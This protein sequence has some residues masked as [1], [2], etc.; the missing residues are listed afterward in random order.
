[1]SS[2]SAL[3]S[4]RYRSQ[5]CA[6]CPSVKAYSQRYGNAPILNIVPIH[7]EGAKSSPLN[8]RSVSL[9]PLF[10]KVLE[11]VVFAALYEHVKPALSDRQ[12]GFMPGR[13][14]T[15][16]LLTMLNTAWNNIAAGSQTDVIYTDFSSAFQSVSHK[17]LLH[18]LKNSYH[19]SGNAYSWCKS[20][21][22]E[23]EQRVV[24]KGKC[25]QWTAAPSGTPEGGLL[26]PLLFACFIND[27]PDNVQA[28]C[29]MFADD[30]KLYNRVDSVADVDFLRQQLDSL[31]RW[32]ARWQLTLNPSKCK[33]LTLT[34]RR[35][36]IVSMYSIGSVQLERVSVMRDLGV[37]LD[38]KLTFS[39]HVDATVRKANRALGMLMRSFQTGKRGKSLRCFNVKAIMATYCANVRTILEY[40]SVVWGGA[41]DVHTNRIERVQHKFL[42]W[43]C[44]RCCKTDVSLEY[45]VLL[46]HY[47]MTPLKA[48]REQHDL[49]FIRNVHRHVVNSSYLLERF[50]LAVPTRHLR[51]M[52]LFHVPF[53]RVNTV[54]NSPFCRIPKLCNSFLD[55]NR[56][57][58]VWM[59]ASVSFKTHVI[60]YVRK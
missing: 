26:S 22:C 36:P 51:N 5:Y 38:E 58:D 10:G 44:C 53:A 15:S 46:N 39:E 59:N 50:P 55:S 7:K 34:L 52:I 18:K 47:G 40:A 29:V 49:M 14:C 4:W 31:C 2:E 6:N 48:R 28:D 21:L 11:R 12:H 19:L 17:L 56:E 13:S 35:A 16:N 57:V 23:R 42:M 8:Y 41:A 60:T 24:V 32:S 25:S 37:L 45:N 20:Y 54:R 9:L 27:L 43:L 30:V 33:V 3:T 1:M